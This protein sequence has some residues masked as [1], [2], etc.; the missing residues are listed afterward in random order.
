MH[1]CSRVHVDGATGSGIRSRRLH[2]TV[3]FSRERAGRM[4]FQI[5]RIERCV[6]SWFRPTEPQPEVIDLKLN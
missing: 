4:V 6:A 2:S 3:L 1:V 5:S